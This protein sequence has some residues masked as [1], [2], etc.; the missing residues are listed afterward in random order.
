MNEIR[1][2]DDVIGQMI[3]QMEAKD[4]AL[5]ELTEKVTNIK[6][7]IKLLASQKNKQI[8][9]LQ[10]ELNEADDQLQQLSEVYVIKEEKL[11]EVIIHLHHRLQM[12]EKTIHTR[13]RE[14]QFWKS[15]A[16]KYKSHTSTTDEGTTEEEEEDKSVS[17]GQ[18][19]V[20][21]KEIQG[22]N[23]FDIIRNGRQVSCHTNRV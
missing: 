23:K 9:D 11:G 21:P 10:D 17:F 4:T 18:V 6:N 8:Q 19:E 2:R 22:K 20:P 1:N 15:R 7:H 5:R 16:M 12:A 14:V 13:A 3:G